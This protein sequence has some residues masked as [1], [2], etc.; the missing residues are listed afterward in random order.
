MSRGLKAPL[1]PNE[2]ATLRSVGQ[3]ATAQMLRKRD[4]ARLF[5]LALVAWQGE[6]VVITPAGL[7]RLGPAPARLNKPAAGYN[8]DDELPPDR[9][10]A[11]AR[12]EEEFRN[13]LNFTTK[14]DRR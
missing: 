12:R 5:Q 6:S 1:S 3:G 2:E 9:A 14:P 4:V 10:A 11:L 13:L 7:R 8:E